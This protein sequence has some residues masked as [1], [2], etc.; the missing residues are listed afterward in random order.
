MATVYARKRGNKWEY[1]FEAAA[2]NG[3]RKQ[4]TKG[5]FRTK[6]EAM[7]AGSKAFTEYNNTG[8]TFTPSEISFSDYLDYWLKQYAKTNLKQTTYENYRK[9]IDNHIRPKLGMYRLKGLQ[10][11]T[12]QDFINGKFNEGYSRNTLS[13]IKGLLNSSFEYAIEPLHFIA[14][15]PYR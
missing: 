8:L 14:V 9:K 5:G 11:A 3:S 10:A 2:I 1:R 15:N 7:A 6:A 4:I 12:L 13:V